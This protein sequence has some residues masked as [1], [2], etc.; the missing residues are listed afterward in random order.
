MPE[1]AFMVNEPLYFTFKAP[2]HLHGKPLGSP[3][4]LLGVASAH[5]L[6]GA[7]FRESIL[8]SSATASGGSRGSG[9]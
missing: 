8:A 6:G 9:W 4:R 5:S 7:S 2:V 1:E 3:W